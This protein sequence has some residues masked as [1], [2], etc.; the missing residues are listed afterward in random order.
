MAF[1]SGSDFIALG[2]K[3]GSFLSFKGSFINDVTHILELITS[4]FVVV[5]A[6]ANVLSSQI[7]WTHSPVTSCMEVPQYK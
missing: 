4:I 1:H 6:K 3:S 5:I 2:A 7:C